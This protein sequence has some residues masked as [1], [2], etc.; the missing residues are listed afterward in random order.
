MPQG[1]LQP[2]FNFRTVIRCIMELAGIIQGCSLI[3]MMAGGWA[4]EMGSNE[5]QPLRRFAVWVGSSVRSIFSW[6]LPFVASRRRRRELESIWAVET[7]TPQ[8]PWRWWVVLGWSYFA[9]SFVHELSA[10]RRA[11]ARPVEKRSVMVA[12]ARPVQAEGDAAG[13]TAAGRGG[14]N[15]NLVDFYFQKQQELHRQKTGATAPV[16]SQIAQ[17]VTSPE[18][19][20]AATAPAGAG[21]PGGYPLLT[22]GSASTAALLATGQPGFAP[23]TT[24]APGDCQLGGYTSTGTSVPSGPGQPGGYPTS[25]CISAQGSQATT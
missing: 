11:K 13:G 1:E 21:Q 19:G 2:Q 4:Q 8:R 7:Y 16:V 5:E 10:Y 3:G 6:V 12:S 23:L 9:A 24:T 25:S 14:S 22:V 18:V 15:S 20:A 17:C